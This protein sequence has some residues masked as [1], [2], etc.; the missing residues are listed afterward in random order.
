MYVEEYQG[1]IA[2]EFSLTSTWYQSHPYSLRPPHNFSLQI[3]TFMLTIRMIT[4]SGYPWKPCP[5]ASL[6]WPFSV[7]AYHP[8]PSISEPNH[9]H[10]PTVS[11]ELCNCI[12]FSVSTM[13]TRIP[14]LSTDFSS[15]AYL[16]LWWL[17]IPIGLK[18]NLARNLSAAHLQAKS[19][20]F[21]INQYQS[22]KPSILCRLIERLAL[23]CSR[24]LVL[25]SSPTHLIIKC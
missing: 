14:D 3:R 25:Q 15:Q 20:K 9:M 17:A 2:E 23:H 5:L 1:L 6:P 12:S 13:H 19:R 18:H 10:K 16:N 24:H 7:W 8:C 11:L 21:S 4:I 22:T